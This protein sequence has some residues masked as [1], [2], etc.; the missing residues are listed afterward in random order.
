MRIVITGGPSSVPI[1]AVRSIT[2]QSTGELA[3]ILAQRFQE[4]GNQVDLLLGRRAI[5]RTPNA[6]FFDTNEDLELLL[7]RVVRR[8]E[9]SM[10][11]HAAALADF[12]VDKVVTGQSKQSKI[13]A[14]ISSSVT[15]VQIW[16]SPKA[17]VIARLRSLFPGAFIV[18]WKFESDGSTRDAVEKAVCQIK[19]HR[20][21]ACV[22][23]G[24]AFGAGFGYCNENGLLHSVGSKSELAELLLR[25]AP[26][27]RAA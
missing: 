25:L 17:K 12:G 26:L 13:P 7:D 11:L 6:H 27:N 2:N 1:D 8:E 24:P 16:L 15:A 23:N 9:V 20:T 14:K 5:F 10:L 19:A 18:G 21:D 3:V 4:A 22:V